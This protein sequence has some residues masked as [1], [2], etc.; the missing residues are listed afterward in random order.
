MTTKIE[1]APPFSC[2]TREI[3]S[4]D[5]CLYN[6]AIN[7]CTIGTTVMNPFNLIFST[8]INGHLHAAERESHDPFDNLPDIRKGTYHQYCKISP[9]N[10]LPG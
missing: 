4:D 8:M 7:V 10:P 2:L 5:D 3:L 6:H 9:C 1:T